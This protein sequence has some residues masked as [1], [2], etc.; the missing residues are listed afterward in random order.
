M[1]RFP[2]EVAIQKLQN[3]PSDCIGAEESDRE[4]EPGNAGHSSSESS[5]SD[6]EMNTDEEDMS[7]HES[8]ALTPCCDSQENIFIFDR[9]RTK[10][11][12]ELFS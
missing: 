9:D 2:A 12:I 6:D 10:W 11:K 8:S 7:L 1:R 5:E 4:T 3:L